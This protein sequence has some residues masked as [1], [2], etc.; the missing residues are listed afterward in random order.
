MRVLLVTVVLLAS[1]LPSAASAADCQFQLGFKAIADQIPD[2]VGQCSENEHYNQRN[3]DSLQATSGGLLVWRK[4]D[5]FTAFTDGYRTWVNGPLGL[6]RRLNTETFQWESPAADAPLPGPAA[7]PIVS[8]PRS[9]GTVTIAPATTRWTDRG[10][11][12]H[13]V[14][15]VRNTTNQTVRLGTVTANAFNGAGQVV[16]VGS[17][18]PPA[19]FVTPGGSSCFHIVLDRAPGLTTV[20]FEGPNYTA[21][22]EGPQLTVSNTS[23]Q[24]DNR[25]GRLT[26]SGMVRNAGSARVS[27]AKAVVVL[28][29][30]AGVVTGCEHGYV[31]ST[32][33]AP[34]QSSSF[35][36]RVYD[37]TDVRR[38]SEVTSVR[39]VPG[40]HLW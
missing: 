24:R 17:T 15:E 16:G 33:L 28:R 27:F 8:P 22:Q 12:V 5:N 7:P 6:Q 37:G 26:V 1:L 14:G 9:P 29:N 39:T 10:G 3:G 32:D 2:V 30:A 20:R 23:T 25:A 21:V 34:G 4:A 18:N 31:S 13:I 11:N 40:G 19:E 35:S 36:V 38:L